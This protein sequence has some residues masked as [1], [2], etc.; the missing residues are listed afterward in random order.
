MFELEYMDRK[1]LLIKDKQRYNSKYQQKLSKIAKIKLNEPRSELIFKNQSLFEVTEEN[2]KLLVNT[3]RSLEYFVIFEIP[4]SSDTFKEIDNFKINP[5]AKLSAE[6]RNSKK[7][8]F[9]Q[10]TMRGREKHIQNSIDNKN[11]DDDNE[12]DIQHIHQE[13]MNETVERLINEINHNLRVPPDVRRYSE[14]TYKISYILKYWYNSYD[15]LRLFLPFPSYQS[16]KKNIN[17]EF[18]HIKNGLTNI[19]YLEDYIKMMLPISEESTDCIDVILSIDAIDIKLFKKYFSEYKSIFIFYALPKD[20]RYKGFPVFTLAHKSG[21]TTFDVKEK[22]KQIISKINNIKGIY[23]PIKAVDGETGNNKEHKDQFKIFL[24][25]LENSGFKKLIESIKQSIEKRE[26]TFIIT[27][28]IHFAKNRRSQIVISGLKMLNKIVNI[29][30]LED[31]LP[32]S[33]AINDKSPLSKLQDTFP[34][35]IFNFVVLKKLIKK[36]QI[37]LVLFLFPIACWMEV[38]LNQKLDRVSRLFLMEI[39]LKIYF[40]LYLIQNELESPMEM[41]PQISLMRAINTLAI[42]YAEFDNDNTEFNFDRY[43]TMPQEHFH[44]Q[45]R[46]I[47]HNNDNYETV[48]NNISRASLVYKYKNEIGIPANVRSRLSVGGLHWKQDTH[49]YTAIPPFSVDDLVEFLYYNSVYKEYAKETDIDIKTIT[50]WVDAVSGGTYILKP[51]IKTFYGKQIITR[52]LSNS[53]DHLEDDF[54]D[55]DKQSK[56][57]NEEINAF[58]SEINSEE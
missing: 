44:G 12:Y 41:Q 32:N 25:I 7:T 28:M 42:L 34:V 29:N 56:T 35:L 49:T 6:I 26:R 37:D 19:N 33:A 30:I 10:R 24:E 20:S 4:P 43:S 1:T 14:E 2:D 58:D 50:E 51:K 22:T 16:I 3:N 55:T 18:A 40:K 9:Q 46:G 11:E 53:K 39:A 27:D 45:I 52:Q 17:E 15:M 38:C 23:I 36:E 8:K 31:I 57:F 13:Q 48:L 54:S 5:L 21:K 47:A